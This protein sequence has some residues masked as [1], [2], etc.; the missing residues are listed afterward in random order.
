M[1]SAV[2]V[3]AA[4]VLVYQLYV[5]YVLARSGLLT[6]IQLWT[7]L[8]LVRFLPFVGATVCHWF[9]RLHGTNEKPARKAR[10]PSESEDGED[11]SATETLRTA[12][13]T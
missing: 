11:A 13:E 10:G 1:I 2:I 8:A 12:D 4:M 7:Q 5:T 9:F 3:L 6:T